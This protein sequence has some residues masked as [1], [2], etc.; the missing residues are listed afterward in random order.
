MKED[1]V[2][3][4]TEKTDGKKLAD[5]GH[6]LLQSVPRGITKTCIPQC[7]NPDKSSHDIKDR[8]RRVFASIPKLQAGSARINQGLRAE[9]GDTE[10]PQNVPEKQV[11]NYIKDNDRADQQGHS[12]T[13]TARFIPIAENICYKHHREE[14]KRDQ[15]QTVERGKQFEDPVCRCEKQ[16][17][18][19]KIH[20]NHDNKRNQ[21]IEVIILG[22]GHSITSL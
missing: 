20:G 15:G 6:R 13:D 1:R 22:C 5:A 4:H 14:I 2:D 8:Q 10:F 19:G 3:N 9:I 11:I 18:E 7:R 17:P 21:A 12:P 16:A